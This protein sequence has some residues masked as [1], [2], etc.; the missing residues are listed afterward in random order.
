MPELY[1]MFDAVVTAELT[2]HS[3]PAP[4]CY[5]TGARLLGFQPSQCVVFEDSKNGLLA[6]R[7]ASRVF[8]RLR[9]YFPK[10]PLFPLK[11]KFY[12]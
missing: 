6:G 4:D 9:D 11:I 2:E 10:N 7:A 3:K 12:G 8:I 5:L 1:D